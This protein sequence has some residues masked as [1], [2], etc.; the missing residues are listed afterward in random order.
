MAFLLRFVLFASLTPAAIRDSSHNSFPKKYGAAWTA[1]NSKIYHGDANYNFGDK[2]EF[3]EIQ[4][5]GSYRRYRLNSFG[6]I[7]ADAE[8]PIN[9]SEI[10]IYTQLQRSLEL[11]ESLE[12]NRASGTNIM[13]SPA[14]EM[15]DI[16]DSA[17]TA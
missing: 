11:N 3:A 10:G 8:G 15:A 16:E 14:A 1:D 12:L 17:I 9:Y 5:G 7:Y 13:E 6:T 4:L 2:I